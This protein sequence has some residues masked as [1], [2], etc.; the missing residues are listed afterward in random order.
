MLLQPLQ[1][2]VC[3]LLDIFFFLAE[4]IIV[5]CEYNFH[6]IRNFWKVKF[7]GSAF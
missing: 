5:A 1:M 2:D 6:Y 7:T 3:I 4:E